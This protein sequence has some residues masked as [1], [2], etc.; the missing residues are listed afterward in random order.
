MDINEVVVIVPSVCEMICVITK[1]AA[2]ESCMWKC[3]LVSI[4][5]NVAVKMD[6]VA[7]SDSCV[8]GKS[9][10]SKI[11]FFDLNDCQIKLCDVVCLN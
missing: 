8:G 1:S 9:D 3:K 5:L 7:L 4:E 6:P 10:K 11:Y 2:T